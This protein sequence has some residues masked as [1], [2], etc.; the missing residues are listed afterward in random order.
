VTGAS[1][2]IG[3]AIALELAL[4]GANVI[5]HASSNRSGAEETAELVRQR[6]RQSTV[7][8]CDIADAEGRLQFVDDCW[9]VAS[10]CATSIDIW[11][12]N[13]GADVLTGDAA[14][15]SFDEKL[16]RLLQVDVQGTIALSREVGKRMAATEREEGTLPSIVNIGWDQA[17]VGMSGDS[18]EMFSAAKGAIMAFTA[19]LAR[20]L[21]P[22]VRVNCVAP[23][24]I[25]T[26]WGDDAPEYWDKRAQKEAL[27]DRWGTSEDVA[28]AVCF[29]VSPDAAFVT[30]QT[31]CVNGGY[32]GEINQP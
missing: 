6:E 24:W 31:I 13:A 28:R 11:V 15:W 23:G 8:L 27:L 1:S 17:A 10:E 3:R 2:G 5:V 7:L 18:G 25:K 12:N 14:N 21:A 19:S 4:R 22:N 26:K 30:G 16:K 29:V 9:Q 20:S 32:R